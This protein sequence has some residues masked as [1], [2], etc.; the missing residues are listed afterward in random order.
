MADYGCFGGDG[1]GGV[2][3]GG[4]CGF[5]GGAGGGGAG[6]GIGGH[7]FSRWSGLLMPV[8]RDDAA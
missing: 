3:G 5:G 1:G 6:F 2:D 7:I 4:G 8:D